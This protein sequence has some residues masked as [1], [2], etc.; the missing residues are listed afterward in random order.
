MA[1]GPT[2]P[3][4]AELPVGAPAGP[5]VM[6]PV[7]A[8]PAAEL[9]RECYAGAAG[10]LARL[11][12]ARSLGRPSEVAPLHRSGPRPAAAGRSAAAP[13]AAGP[14]AA[15]PRPTPRWLGLPWCLGPPRHRLPH[16]PAP[17]S[18]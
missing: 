7:A 17:R 3:P 8:G 14:P 11:A 2:G 16:A 13:P 12:I 15:G 6:G 10:P 18:Y 9:L 4:A 5:P 1:A